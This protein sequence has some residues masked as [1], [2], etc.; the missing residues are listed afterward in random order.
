MASQTRPVGREP[1]HQAATPSPLKG[2][3]RAQR[4]RFAKYHARESCTSA[5]ARAFKCRWN[6]MGMP[7]AK[8]TCSVRI[9][10][11][12]VSPTL[13]PY[14]SLPFRSQ[15]LSSMCPLGSLQERESRLCVWKGKG[16][17][18]ERGDPLACTCIWDLCRAQCHRAQDS[19]ARPVMGAC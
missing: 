9:Q 14:Q 11:G 6:P 15:S 2:D 19:G 3:T 5:A 4:E 12:C 1:L 16:G 10:G 18:E 8:R 7:D 13:H 17:V